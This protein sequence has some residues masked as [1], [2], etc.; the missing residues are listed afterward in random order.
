[1]SKK[2]L[3]CEDFLCLA[4]FGGTMMLFPNSLAKWC[5]VGI[6]VTAA[7]NTMDV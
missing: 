3:I 1:M 6:Y 5:L 4:P 2:C 7:S